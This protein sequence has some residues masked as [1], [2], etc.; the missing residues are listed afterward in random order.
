MS[1]QEINVKIFKGTQLEP[2]LQEQINSWLNMNHNTVEVIDIKYGYTFGYT[3]PSYSAMAV[4]RK[5]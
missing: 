2:E 5:K 3:A 4:Y 1:A